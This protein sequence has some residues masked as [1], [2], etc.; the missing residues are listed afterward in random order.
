MQTLPGQLSYR[1][2]GWVDLL[3]HSPTSVCVHFGNLLIFGDVNSL[4]SHWKESQCYWWLWVLGKSGV[5]DGEHWWKLLQEEE[6]IPLST[7][8][9][10]PCFSCL[11]YRED[12]QTSGFVPK[13]LL[14]EEQQPSIY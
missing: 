5:C 3:R 14:V 7:Y 8:Q 6:A 2:R 11:Q 12:D 10:T 4:Q 1:R 13:S 9:T